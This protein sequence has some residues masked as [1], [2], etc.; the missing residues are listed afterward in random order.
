MAA[1]DAVQAT[2]DTVQAARD[3]PSGD[4]PEYQP[5]GA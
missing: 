2:R 1:H 3:E 5:N 4:N